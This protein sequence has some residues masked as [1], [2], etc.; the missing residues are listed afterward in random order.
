MLVSIAKTT[1]RNPSLLALLM[2]GGGEGK[3]CFLKGKNYFAI[4]NLTMHCSLFQMNNKMN[5]LAVTK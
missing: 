4:P 1:N 3:N 2:S 5:M